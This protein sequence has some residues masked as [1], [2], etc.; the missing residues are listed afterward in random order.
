MA[1]LVKKEAIIIIFN[2]GLE[3]KLNVGVCG[4]TVCK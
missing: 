1:S 3:K 4:R 2:G